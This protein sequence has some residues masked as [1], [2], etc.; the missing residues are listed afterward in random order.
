MQVGVR[1]RVRVDRC[2][3]TVSGSVLC[4]GHYGGEKLLNKYKNKTTHGH[5]THSSEV[6][7]HTCT[8]NAVCGELP[9]QWLHV[10]VPMTVQ[11]PAGDAQVE[12]Q[13][14]RMAITVD[15]PLDVVVA[16]LAS[17]HP[18]KRSRCEKDVVG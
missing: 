10:G 3:A 6:L 11:L 5:I 9:G 8:D 4:A 16:F 12:A 2:F 13:P 17:T 7:C 1:V 18:E 14:W 15:V